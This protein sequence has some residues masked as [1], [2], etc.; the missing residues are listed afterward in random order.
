MVSQLHH[1]DEQSE[2]V[3]TG[4]DIPALR[5]IST[6]LYGGLAMSARRITLMQS[7][8]SDIFPAVG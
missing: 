5:Q 6:A 2:K 1:A 4:S 8:L 3:K 7:I